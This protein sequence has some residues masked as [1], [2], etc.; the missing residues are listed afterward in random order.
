MRKRRLFLLL[1][2]VG[3]LAT[4]LVVVFN[5]EREPEYQGRR[6]SFWVRDLPWQDPRSGHALADEAILHIGTNAIPYLVKWMQYEKPAWKA[7]LYWAANIVL[8]GV[9]RDWEI[10]D[11]QA[12]RARG[13]KYAFR[14]LGPNAHAA[15]RD[16]NRLMTEAQ[17]DSV[18]FN[19]AS[20]LG[21][22]GKDGLRPLSSGLTNQ[23][24]RL[25][26]FC[27]HSIA[28]LG[29][30][31]RPAVPLLIRCLQDKYGSIG[32]IAAGTLGK[33]RLE[34]D[35]V[36]PALLDCLQPSNGV[37]RIGAATALGSFG[38]DARGAV[39]ALLNSLSDTTSAM[40]L[41]ATNALLQ[42]DPLALERAAP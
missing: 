5:R 38:R 15:V 24:G 11:K 4:V 12:L 41:A 39:P 40:R 3:V 42:I 28:D 7:K 30:N 29:T 20:A 27:V 18:S 19:A 1:I 21:H 16:L 23:Q 25:R 35:L 36:I 8:N 2:A 13:A 22:L 14:S 10:L 9:N 6:L 34:P 17:S 33:L 32:W 37:V 31:A 26:A